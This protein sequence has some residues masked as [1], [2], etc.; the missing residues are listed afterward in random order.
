MPIQRFRFIVV[1]C[2]LRNGKWKQRRFFRGKIAVRPHTPCYQAT[3]GKKS[4]KVREPGK[5][6]GAASAR[7]RRDL[8]LEKV[9]KDYKLRAV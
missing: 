9:G 3:T 5:G 7:H 8:M 6:R 2:G 1:S 4:L